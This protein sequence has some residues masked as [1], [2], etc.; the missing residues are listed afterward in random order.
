MDPHARS[1]KHVSKLT[2]DG[3]GW[4]LGLVTQTAFAHGEADLLGERVA[5]QLLQ[6]FC[7]IFHNGAIWIRLETPKEQ[8]SVVQFMGGRT[9]NQGWANIGRLLQDSHFPCCYWRSFLIR[10][11][12]QVEPLTIHLDNANWA[13]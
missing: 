2:L 7:P 6:I 13:A 11:K 5:S 3:F 8:L 4:W 10:R 9:R 1:P 12:D